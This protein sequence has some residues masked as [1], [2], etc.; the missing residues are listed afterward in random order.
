MAVDAEPYE[1]AESVS[2]CT[3]SIVMA[4][5]TT[6]TTSMSTVTESTAVVNEPGQ[7]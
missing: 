5:S 4:K 1:A 3:T 7:G 6:T 2:A